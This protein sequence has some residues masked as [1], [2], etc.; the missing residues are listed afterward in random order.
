MYLNRHPIM[1]ELWRLHRAGELNEAQSLLFNRP[2]AI[3]ELYDTEADPWETRNLAGDPR[4]ADDLARLRDALDAWR[5]DVGDLGEIPESEMVRRW[6]PD[7]HQPRTAAPLVIALDA[8]HFGLEPID[9]QAVLTAPALVQ[10]HSATQGASIAWRLDDGDDQPGWRLYTDPLRL[11]R[12]EATVR[13]RAIRIGYSESEETTVTVR[14][15]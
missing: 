3:E 9:G 5:R 8:D 10:L 7:G 13:A 14:V 11:P 2:R 15:E 4:Y 6:Y 12:G 1:R